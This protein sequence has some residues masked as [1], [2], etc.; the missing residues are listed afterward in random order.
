VN[1]EESGDSDEQSR[2]SKE[3][4]VMMSVANEA[5]NGVGV[6][7]EKHY[8]PDELADLLDY[9]VDTHLSH[10]SQNPVL[11]VGRDEQMHRRKKKSIRIPHPIYV[12]WHERHRATK[13]AV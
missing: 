13:K 9:S 8:K 5:N 12:R 6:C 11:E 10:I 7:V 1:F 3:D 4:T 2:R